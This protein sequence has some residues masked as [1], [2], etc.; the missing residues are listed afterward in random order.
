[1]DV[2]ITTQGA[3]I[4]SLKQTMEPLNKLATALQ[5]EKGVET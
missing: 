3:T 1:M 5:G 4:Q 2:P